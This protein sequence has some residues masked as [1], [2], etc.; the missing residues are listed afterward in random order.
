MCKIGT[1]KNLEGFLEAGSEFAIELSKK[2]FVPEYKDF[3]CIYFRETKELKKYLEEKDLLKN[4]Q[5]LL[6]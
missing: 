4:N 5:S 3:K 1:P 6:K 2:G